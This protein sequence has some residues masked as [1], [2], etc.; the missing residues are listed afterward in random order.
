MKKYPFHAEFHCVRNVSYKSINTATNFSNVI[1]AF[2]LVR[3]IRRREEVFRERRH[4]LYFRLA[5]PQYAQLLQYSFVHVRPG[6]DVL[7]FRD[8]GLGERDCFRS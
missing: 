5:L 7:Q 1:P 2:Y 6:S 8:V 4:C 3:Q